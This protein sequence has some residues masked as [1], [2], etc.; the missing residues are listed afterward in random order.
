MMEGKTC[1][2]VRPLLLTPRQAAK[3]LGICERTLWGLSASGELPRLKIGAAV[4]YHV[5]D[6]EA[7]IERAKNSQESS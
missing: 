2:C 5:N 4:R 6:L 1:D 3:A 7:W